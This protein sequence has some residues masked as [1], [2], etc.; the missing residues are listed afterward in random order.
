MG[1]RGGVRNLTSN[2]DESF[3]NS[4]K[5][6]TNFFQIVTKSSLG[7]GGGVGNRRFRSD[8]INGS[9]LRYEFH[10][11]HF[12]NFCAQIYSEMCSLVC[13]KVNETH[14]AAKTTF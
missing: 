13:F 3:S 9:S 14:F 4:E 8:V 10:Q 1:G 6:V 12:S 11:V 2:S 7:E 5:L